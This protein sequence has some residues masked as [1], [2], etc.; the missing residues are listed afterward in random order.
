MLNK[1]CFSILL[2]VGYTKINQIRENL[3]YELKSNG[4]QIASFISKNAILYSN[5]VGEGSIILPSTYIGPNVKIGLCNYFAAGV[6]ISHDSVIGNF[7]FL[8]TNVINN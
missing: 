4:Y 7:N 6:R 3:Y 8:S 2:A 5:D 1:S